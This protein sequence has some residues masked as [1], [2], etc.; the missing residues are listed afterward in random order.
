MTDVEQLVKTTLGE[1]ERILSTK[2]VIGEPMIVEGNT[3]IPMVS[4]GFGFGGGSG[5]G[6]KDKQEGS[7]AGTGGGGGIKPLGIIV[8]NAD[9]V[10]VEPIKGASAAMIE[11]VAG[12][13]TKIMEKR[14]EKKGE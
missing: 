6:G 11:A 1:I 4:I 13:I 7:G 10:K 3:I 2:A 8:V 12:G 9:G 14:Q 5:S